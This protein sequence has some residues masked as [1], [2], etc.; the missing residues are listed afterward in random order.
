MQEIAAAMRGYAK[1]GAEH[2]MFQREPYAPRRGRL[3]EALNSIADS[4]GANLW[5]RTRIEWGKLIRR[6]VRK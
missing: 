5:R 6:S 3:T 1:L 4:T 2:I